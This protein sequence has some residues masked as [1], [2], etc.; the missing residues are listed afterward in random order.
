MAYQRA[1]KL[2]HN[3]GRYTGR[4]RWSNGRTAMEDR[5]LERTSYEGHAGFALPLRVRRTWLEHSHDDGKLVDIVDNDKPG[6]NVS[7]YVHP[8]FTYVQDCA[9]THSVRG[10]E[11]AREFDEWR[12]NADSVNPDAICLHAHDPH[13]ALLV[14]P[15]P[16][17]ATRRRHTQPMAMQRNR[18]YTLLPG[19]AM[20]LGWCELRQDDMEWASKI[21]SRLLAKQEQ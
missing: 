21:T 9:A 20:H 14:V 2:E 18:R 10:R 7:D 11:Q 17:I 5:E 6:Y 1:A 16:G 3:E 13:L 15:E 19:S 12:C 4:S 8:A